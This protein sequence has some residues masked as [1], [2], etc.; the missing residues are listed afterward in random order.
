MSDAS[1]A[2]SETASV[3]SSETASIAE[4]V[5]ESTTPLINLAEDLSVSAGAVRTDVPHI[6]SSRTYI[7]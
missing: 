2:I 7:L 4:S 3:A 5:A 6:R 1:R